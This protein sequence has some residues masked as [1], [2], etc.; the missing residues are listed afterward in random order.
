MLTVTPIIT[1]QGFVVLQAT[2]PY[3]LTLDS[4]QIQRAKTKATKISMNAIVHTMHK[5]IKPNPQPDHPPCCFRVNTR[6]PIHGRTEYTESKFQ[7]YRDL[8]SKL[9]HPT[10]HHTKTSGIPSLNF[11]HNPIAQP[12]DIDL[13]FFNLIDKLHPTLRRNIGRI[14]SITNI[15][16]MMQS[17][18]NDQLIAVCDA[19]VNNSQL[20][21]HSYIIETLDEKHH[22][23]GNAPVDCDEDDCESTRAKKSGVLALL[24]IIEIMEQ[25]SS[26]SAGSM[27]V[28]CD[29]KE[30]VTI[31]SPKKYLQSYNFFTSNNIDLDMEIRAAISR[32]YVKINLC[33]I[34]GHQDDKGDFDYD[35]A[36]Q[37]LKNPPKYLQPH[38]MTP[39]YPAQKLWLKIHNTT[40]TSNIDAH[41]KLHK[42]GP[43][44]ESR[45]IAKTIIPSTFISWVQWRGLERAMNRHK[46]LAKIPIV[47]KFHDKLATLE[48]IASWHSGMQPTCL[49]CKASDENQ[50]HDYQCKSQHARY[51]NKRV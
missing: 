31:R 8:W 41:I 23:R 21:A 40:I 16:K 27:T 45:L 51:N 26:C 44:M 32:C 49:R 6:I 48:Q 33:H 5:L 30:S 15:D 25:L 24:T 29:N 37:C 14:E 20:A 19:S 3:S 17:F 10:H 13:E 9:R 42:N 18:E 38:R 1:H 12:C 28:Y 7:Y 22:I 36:P 11:S 4:I 47:K 2:I 46:S 35:T 39:A 50:Y 43:A 34:Y